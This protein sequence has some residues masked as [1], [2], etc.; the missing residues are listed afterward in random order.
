MEPGQWRS[1][2]N[3]GRRR[4]ALEEP[5]LT[6]SPGADADATPLP[7]EGSRTTGT[8]SPAPALANPADPADPANAPLL[9]SH[10]PSPHRTPRSPVALPRGWARLRRDLRVRDGE[11]FFSPPAGAR[12]TSASGVP[13]LRDRALYRALS[14]ADAGPS[15]ATA[16]ATTPRP[17]RLG[18]FDDA[19]ALTPVPPDAQQQRDADLLGRLRLAVEYVLDAMEGLTHLSFR[20]EVPAA[21]RIAKLQRTRAYAWTLRALLLAHLALLFVEP[22]NRHA[23]DAGDPSGTHST[24]PY[25]IARRRRL[26]ALELVL[27]SVFVATAGLDL[28][29]LGWERYRAKHWRFVFVGASVAVACDAVVALV[30]LSALPPSSSSSTRASLLLLRPTRCLRPLLVV[31]HHRPTRQLVSSAARTVPMLA[32]TM[33]LVGVVIVAWACAGVQLYQGA[34]DVED[35]N[36][37]RNFDNG[38]DA[39]TAMTVLITVE[40]FPDVMRPALDDPRV[41]PFVTAVF[42]VSF[43]VLATWLGMSL[44]VTVIFETYKS[45]HRGKIA[46]QRVHEQKALITAFSVLQDTPNEPVDGETWVRLARMARPRLSEG[47]ARALL[48]V[49][50]EKEAD[51]KADAKER[52]SA[53]GEAEGPLDP[54]RSAWGETANGAIEIDRRGSNGALGDGA[55]NSALAGGSSDAALRGARGV[56]N[57]NVSVDAFLKTVDVLKSG[58]TKA[59]DP[60]ALVTRRA[61]LSAGLLTGDDDAEALFEGRRSVEGGS[62]AAPFLVAA[63]A[64]F[65]SRVVAWVRSRWFDRLATFASLA[66]TATLLARHRRATDRFETIVDRCD[67]A[68]VTALVVELLLRAWVAW[69]RTGADEPPGTFRA[70]SVYEREREGPSGSSPLGFD[71]S[72]TDLRP[73]STGPVGLRGF[74]AARAFDVCVAAPSAALAL[75]WARAFGASAAATKALT[76]ARRTFAP[77]RILRLCALSNA[78]REIVGVFARCGEV[79]ATLL[80]C[81]A[82]CAYSYACVGMESFHSSVTGARP[83]CREGES[84]SDVPGALPCLDRHENFEAPWSALLALFQVSTSNNWH[85]ILYPNAAAA[86][87][88]TGGDVGRALAVLY[89]ASFYAVAVLLLVN[90]LTS[91][92][93]EM[94][95]AHWRATGKTFADDREG[96]FDD[97]GRTTRR[98][99]ARETDDAGEAARETSP[100][101]FSGRGFSAGRILG[102]IRG[103]PRGRRRTTEGAPV[104]VVAPARA[105]RRD[106]EGHAGDGERRAMDRDGVEGL[107]EGSHARGAEPSEGARGAR[108]GAGPARDAAGEE[109]E[110]ARRASARGDARAEEGAREDEG[111]SERGGGARG[112]R[113]RPSDAPR[114]RAEDARARRVRSGSGSGSGGAQAERERRE[115]PRGRARGTHRG[116]VGAHR[117]AR[118][119]LGDVKRRGGREERRRKRKTL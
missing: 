117:R 98:G 114:G 65:E 48:T 1:P 58:V 21:R 19:A 30:A 61:R 35:A 82:C 57:Q 13:L 86:K 26:L 53:E 8:P 34:Y 56:Q 112:A 71:R 27:A 84:P 72:S 119:G 102:R 3:W 55:Q 104:S 14:D 100:F 16:R 66:Q 25:P 40:N 80:A 64:T 24:T 15:P 46:R 110:R 108:A 73:A 39:A 42:F 31:S 18:A 49:L 109:E 95:G 62:S 79:I 83:F 68:C 111:A 51:A 101:S 32:S 105:R 75:P 87:A 54:K 9:P 107:G 50:L 91:L 22:H 115:R 97:P 33:A 44:W 59:R 99:G 4:P 11:L 118:G 94:F 69:T 5:L 37:A 47:A 93:L 70:P 77:V 6:P 88:A 81:L 89:F 67:A 7:S 17:A 85:D 63:A 74:F 96:F 43:I 41:P 38:F 20:R 60:D 12:P 106:R 10:P 45:Q 28:V 76:R 29:R 36:T 113:R 2:T 92:V 78:Q 103:R 90:I 23:A 116:G 52:S